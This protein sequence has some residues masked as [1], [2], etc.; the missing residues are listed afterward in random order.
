MKIVETLY[1][2]DMR[3]HFVM[4]SAGSFIRQQWMMWSLSKYFIY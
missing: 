1:I 3:V 4:S 2:K